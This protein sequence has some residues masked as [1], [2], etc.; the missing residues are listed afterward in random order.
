MLGGVAVGRDRYRLNR[1]GGRSRGQNDGCGRLQTWS[2]HP[3]D[4][5]LGGWPMGPAGPE[6]IINNRRRSAHNGGCSSARMIE[7]AT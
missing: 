4:S 2:S 1:R 3:G 6:A 7:D 5:T